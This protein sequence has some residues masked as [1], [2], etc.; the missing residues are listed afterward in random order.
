VASRARSRLT[1]NMTNTANLPGDS[2]GP[3]TLFVPNHIIRYKS[4][5]DGIVFVQII[6]REKDHTTGVDVFV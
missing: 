3:L 6:R 1:K 5:L 2:L 4:I